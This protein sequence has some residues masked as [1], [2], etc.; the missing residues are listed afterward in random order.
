MNREEDLKK[1]DVT[2]VNKM[3]ILVPATC[4]EIE[5]EG[6]NELNDTAKLTM[7]SESTEHRGGA[8]P[9]ESRNLHSAPPPLHH[10]HS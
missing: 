10:S 8:T 5:R 6:D 2:A 4:L 7:R 9:T 3:M 1:K